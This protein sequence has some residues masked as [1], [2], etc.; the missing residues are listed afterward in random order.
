MKL[1][2]GRRNPRDLYLQLGDQP[3]DQDPCVGF[4]IDADTAP[5]IADALVSPW[6]LGEIKISAQARERYENP[7]EPT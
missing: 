7:M 6:H 1:R 2:P 3:D 5:L 4:M